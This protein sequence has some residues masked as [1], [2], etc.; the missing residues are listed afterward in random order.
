M[1]ASIPRNRTT[2]NYARRSPGPDTENL[3][4][5]VNDSPPNEADTTNI[6]RLLELRIQ[7][8]AAQKSIANKSMRRATDFVAKENNRHTFLSG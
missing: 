4:E 1:A 6:A 7:L 3:I 5:D 8:A 2:Y